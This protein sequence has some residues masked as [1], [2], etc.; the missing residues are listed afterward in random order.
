MDAVLTGWYIGFIIATVVI[1]VVVVLVAIILGLARRIATQ[2][3]GIVV[4]LDAGRINTL[5]LWQVDNINESLRR[6]T[7]YAE[8]A[9]V[10]LGG[11]Q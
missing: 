3:E 11:G 7:R 2:A 5:P 1:S 8:Q 6:T 9:R 10:E 4:G